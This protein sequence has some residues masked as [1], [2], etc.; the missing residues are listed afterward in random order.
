MKDKIIIKNIYHLV[1]GTSVSDGDRMMGNK[2]KK[3]TS[4][5]SFED[6]NYWENPS[7]DMYYSRHSRKHSGVTRSPGTTAS[8][9]R[10]NGKKAQDIKISHFLRYGLAFCHRC[11]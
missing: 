10:G 5:D 6:G 1:E 8:P 3:Q 9:Y 2:S 4:Y 11:C 7:R